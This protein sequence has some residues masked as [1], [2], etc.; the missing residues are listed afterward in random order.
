MRRLPRIAA[1]LIPL[2]AS[3]LAPA[4][5][6]ELRVHYSAVQKLLLA[7]FFVAEGRYYLQGS[8]ETPCSFASLERPE[9]FARDGRL[10]IRMQFVSKV[11]T[12]VRSNCLGTGDSFSLDLSGVPVYAGGVIRLSDVAFT[13]EKPGVGSLIGPL[14]TGPLAEAMQFP[15]QERIEETAQALWAETGVGLKVP[16]IEVPEI[17]LGPH[18]MRVP[19][20]FQV[21]LR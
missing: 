15:L 21:E 6:G 19:F 13:A 18:Q 10:F 16:M 4:E 17:V 8:Q 9:V 5:A 1:L 11:G 7:R 20:D 12:E 2:A 3:S 14:V